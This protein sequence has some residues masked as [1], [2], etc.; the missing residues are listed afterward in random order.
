MYSDSNF[1]PLLSR[2]ASEPS[3]A[4]LLRGA[5]LSATDQYNGS[6]D[7]TRGQSTDN[8]T[9]GEITTIEF[10]SPWLFFLCNLL[11]SDVITAFSRAGPSMDAPPSPRFLLKIFF[12][13]GGMM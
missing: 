10:M 7:D 12:L 2:L 13:K 4:S 11:R 6:Q 5:S 3:M 8:I 9:G 1:P